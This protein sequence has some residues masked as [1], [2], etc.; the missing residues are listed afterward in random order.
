[1][2]EVQGNSR[3]WVSWCLAAA[4]SVL[5]A[6]VYNPMSPKFR[7]LRESSE[8]PGRLGVTVRHEMHL[9][10]FGGGL[11]RLSKGDNACLCTSTRLILWLLVWANLSRSQC[12]ISSEILL[13]HNTCPNKVRFSLLP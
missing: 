4:Q 11:E 6:P 8:L 13:R 10:Q 5:I 2:F 7:D 1:M 9:S 3:L 12:T